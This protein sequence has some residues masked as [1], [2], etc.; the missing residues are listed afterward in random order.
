MTIFDHRLSREYPFRVAW[1]LLLLLLFLTLGLSVKHFQFFDALNHATLALFMA[2]HSH[3]SD[4]FFI[5]STLL[6][7]KPYYYVLGGG[8]LIWLLLYHHWRAMVFIII[9]VTMVF[10]LSPLLKH[11]FVITRPSA[12]VANIGYAFPSGHAF[13]ANVGFGFF[14]LLLTAHLKGGRKYGMLLLYNIPTILV[15]MSRVYLG[16]HWLTDVIGGILIAWSLNLFAFFIYS[17]YATY[18]VKPNKALWLIGGVALLVFGYLVN[19]HLA[20]K[21]DFYQKIANALA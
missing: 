4:I 10:Y 21:L 2:H 12:D 11:V 15:S 13:L 1:P 7:D 3:A 18:C 19:L 5:S 8:I 16:V 9:A 14:S 6:C 17:S 20:Q